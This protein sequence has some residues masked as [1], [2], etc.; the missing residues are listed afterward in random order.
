M[1]KSAILTLVCVAAGFAHAASSRLDDIREVGEITVAVYENFPPFSFRE[2]NQ[3]RG[4]DVEIAEEFAAKIGVKPIIRVVGADESV[5]DDLR[6][7]IWKGHYL[8]GGVADV[9][10]HVPFDRELQL[11]NDRVRLVGAYY[12]EQI[13]IALSAEHNP[14]GDVLELFTREKVGVELDTLADFYLLTANAGRIRHNVV[15]FTRVADAVTALLA[16]RLTGVM[17]PRSEIEGAAG[18]RIDELVL[19]EPGRLPGLMR[20]GWDLGL[21][22]KQGHDALAEAVQS[23]LGELHSSGRL[24]EIFAAYGVTYQPASQMRF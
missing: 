5:E 15:H 2:G 24:A 9:M 17:A 21:A 18:K 19:V 13:V 10:V 22:V 3:L 23:A 20:T 6:N 8:G 1:F 7:N 14:A 12:R 16:G 4:I 11:R